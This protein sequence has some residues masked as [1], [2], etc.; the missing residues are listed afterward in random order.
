MKMKAFTRLLLLL[1][2]AMSTAMPALAVIIDPPYGTTVQYERTEQGS[3][4]YTYDGGTMIETTSQYG[5]LEVTYTS[6]STCYIK[7]ILG[8]SAMEFGD[9]WVMGTLS[10]DGK[11]ITV[12]MGQ[13]IYVIDD[14]ITLS[15]VVLGWGTVH[16]EYSKYNKISFTKD[17]SVSAV[18]YAIDGNTIHIEGTSGPVVVDHDDDYLYASG[19]CA[20]W[21]D[22]VATEHPFG[23]FA[24]FIEWSTTAVTDVP[25]VIWEQPD[26]TRVNYY[27]TGESVLYGSNTAGSVSSIDSQGAIVY[28]EDGT[29]VFLKD[30]VFNMAYGTWVRGSI[31][32][33]SNRI[34]VPM[35]QCIY[36]NDDSKS[37]EETVYLNWGKSYINGGSISYDVMDK[38]LATYII[39]G[40][41]ISLE[42]SQG[43]IGSEYPFN[44]EAEG[45]YAF[46]SAQG[47]IEAHT[48]YSLSSQLDKTPM[49][50]ATYQQAPGQYETTVTIT[51]AEGDI[52]YRIILDGIATG[53][54]KYD[55]EFVVSDEGDYRIEY[56]AIA[57]GK[58][59]SDIG[60]IEFSIKAFTGVNEVN[61]GKTVT[62]VRYYNF[63]GQQVTQPRGVTIQVTT[64]SDG[65][66]SAV[67]VV[68]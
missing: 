23:E 53:W 65:T 20:I 33:G 61:V 62:S 16:A 47:A 46:N 1:I 31:N 19:P 21:E 37:G 22:V 38:D 51:A 3:F 36:Y 40:N 55:G 56:Y 66:T 68:E 2:M 49:P 59:R 35:G 28:S 7:N 25:Y 43:N 58:S 50:E 52:Y 67:K 4:I 24:G 32:E 5:P 11:T 64:Y 9:Y 8:G 42:G 45:L 13:E 41:T 12:P 39:E 34:I 27:R 44:L 63:A 30:P 54:M 29:T 6:T 60:A 57:N 17:M 14:N 18:T 15:R 10:P 48:V 26:G